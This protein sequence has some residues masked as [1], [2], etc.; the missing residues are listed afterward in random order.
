MVSGA[1]IL[2]FKGSVKTPEPIF[3]QWL[4]Q[5]YSIS[6]KLEN[7][8]CSPLITESLENLLAIDDSMWPKVKQ[9]F[10]SGCS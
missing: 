2:Y 9:L 1:P 3:Y 7:G 8:K 4:N 5:V 10:P 6:G